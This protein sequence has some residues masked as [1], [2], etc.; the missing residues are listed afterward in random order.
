MSNIFLQFESSY[1]TFYLTSIETFSPFR[2][3]SEIIRV[4]RLKVA[5]NDGM[6]TFQGEDHRHIFFMF[7]CTHIK[8]YKTL[9]KG[10]T[11]WTLRISVWY[12]MF[13]PPTRKILPELNF[14]RLSRMTAKSILPLFFFKSVYSDVFGMRSNFDMF[15]V[16]CKPWVPIST[17]V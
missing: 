6:W 11:E 2:T 12:I 5:W 17:T 16:Q 8:K 10:K 3:V 13:L 7:S 15:I 9:K 14:A 4:K 1:M